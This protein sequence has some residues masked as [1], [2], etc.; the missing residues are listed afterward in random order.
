MAFESR[1]KDLLGR[2]VEDKGGLKE[3]YRG[4]SV[5]K[6]CSILNYIPVIFKSLKHS[7]TGSFQ[8]QEH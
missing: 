7:Q 1:I 8:I 3:S 6:I 2:R 4:D 5:I